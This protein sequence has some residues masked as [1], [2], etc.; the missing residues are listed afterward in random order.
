MLAVPAESVI[1]SG[2]AQYVFV[3]RG[4]GRFEPRA[5]RVGAS[6]G[7]SVEILEGLS[8]GEQVVTRAGFLIDAKSRM[9]AAVEAF[10]STR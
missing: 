7:G 3:A 6:A 2:D 4:E 1:D 5:V 9:R 8:E 10:G